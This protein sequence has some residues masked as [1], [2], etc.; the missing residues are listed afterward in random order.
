MK[1]NSRGSSLQIIRVKDEIEIMREGGSTSI[2][3]GKTQIQVKT[4]NQLDETNRRNA[5]LIQ[6]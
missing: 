1:G 4:T 2:S 6:L 5:E 3:D